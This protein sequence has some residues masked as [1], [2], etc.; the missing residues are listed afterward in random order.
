MNSL[1]YLAGTAFAICY[2]ATPLVRDAL[3]RAGLVDRPDQARK[4][5]RDAVPRLGGIPILAAVAAALAIFA[6]VEGGA[7]AAAVES[8]VPLVPAALLVFAVGVADDLWDLNAWLKLA[9]QFAAAAW[10]WFA[11]LRIDS[12]SGQVFSD[13]AW[14]TFPL[15][16]LWLLA[17]TNAFNLIDGIDGLASGVGLF[18]TTTILLSALLKGDEE[19]QILTIPLAAA[20]LAFLRYNFNPATIFLGDSGA[21]LIGFL[22]GGYSILWS[23]KSATLLAMTAPVFA[24]AFPI[25][26]TGVSVAR[27]WLRGAPIFGADRGHIHHRLLEKGMGPRQAA[28]VLYGVSALGAAVSLVVAGPAIRERGLVV[29]LFAVI[30]AIGFRRLGYTEFSSAKRFV[31]GGGARKLLAADIR[32]R[33]L[34]A[35][36]DSSRDFEDCWETLRVGLT[37]FGF[38]SVELRSEDRHKRSVLRPEQTGASWTLE[39]PLPEIDAGACVRLERDAQESDETYVLDPVI[40]AIRRAIPARLSKGDSL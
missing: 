18:A 12:I 9:G 6:R 33:N 2:L 34:A 15:T 16:V 4:R 11:G 26:E 13:D 22:L 29:I 36:M 25:A 17:A 27:R 31:W 3:L 24:L 19:L 38:R 5:H 8:V 7:F 28:M 39:V 30:A 35:A 37:E 1:I 32:A 20:L 21:M 23:H 14:V 40:G 10:L